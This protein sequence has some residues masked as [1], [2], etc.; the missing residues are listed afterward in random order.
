MNDNHIQ[1]FHALPKKK[2]YGLMHELTSLCMGDPFG[3]CGRYSIKCISFFIEYKT[4]T[5]KNNLKENQ[6]LQELGSRNL[7]LLG[8]TRIVKREF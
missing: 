8:F 1:W 5:C 7:K 4:N 3:V 2:M 6:I